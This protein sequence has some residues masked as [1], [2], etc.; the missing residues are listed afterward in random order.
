VQKPH[1]KLYW[2]K[3]YIKIYLNKK[4]IKREIIII[5]N[6]QL[7]IKLANYYQVWMQVSKL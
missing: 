2:K 1:L 5:T 7:K 4:L 3:D 6:D